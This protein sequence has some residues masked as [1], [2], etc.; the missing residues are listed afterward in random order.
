MNIGRA[1][2]QRQ[3]T[4]IGSMSDVAI[5]TLAQVLTFA[6]LCLCEPRAARA[7]ENLKL[8]YQGIYHIQVVAERR[9][10]NLR[11]S[12]EIREEPKQ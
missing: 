8:P 5:A 9:F 6:Q 3:M 11:S 7:R 1:D 12:R 10:V 2:V 4:D